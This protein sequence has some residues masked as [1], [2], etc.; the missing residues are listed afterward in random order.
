MREVTEVHDQ[1]ESVFDMRY[2]PEQRYQVRVRSDLFNPDCWDLWEPGTKQA[3]HRRHR[4]VLIDEHVDRIIGDG[5]RAHLT[6]HDITYEIETIPSGEEHKTLETV[7]YLLSRAMKFQL[8][9]RAEPI[10]VIGGGVTCD[11]AGVVASLL[12]KGTPYVVV[13]TTWVGMID[14]GIAIK[15]AVNHEG[16]KNAI[17][18]YHPA[19]A[20]TIVPSLLATLPR[21]ELRWGMAEVMKIAVIQDGPRLFEILE[22][23]DNLYDRLQ[24]ATPDGD[25]IAYEV[26]VRALRGMLSALRSNPH[27][28]SLRRWVDFA[29][30]V[31]GGWELA[32]LA[33]GRHFPHGQAVSCEIALMVQLACQ[34]G[35]FGPEDRDRVFTVMDSLEL[36]TWD[37]LMLDYETLAKSLAGTARH[38]DGKQH[39]PIPQT[40]G[41][42]MFLEDVTVPELRS[43][44]EALTAA[45]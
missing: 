6:A 38:R 28:D 34:R 36:P 44:I 35:E 3:D 33:E 26:L 7:G 24:H 12:S 42:G 4:F 41:S 8:L 23:V 15:R 2:A 19:R 45:A 22:S 17:G 5:I 25:P 40:I 20:V 37:P 31:S 16:K 11:I 39:L 32:A 27:E 43:S 9:R 10:I 1:Y 18:A 14:A 13:P 29:H 30:A 21:D